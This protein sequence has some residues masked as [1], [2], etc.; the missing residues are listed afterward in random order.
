MLKDIK[1]LYAEDEEFIRENMVESLEFFSANVIAVSDGDTAYEVYHKEK[2]DI[3]IAD[4]EMP[5]MNGLVLA[6]NIRKKDKNVQIIITTA[7][8]NTQYL[9]K[10][11]ELNL[12]KYLTK[13]VRLIDL[14]KALNTCIE[15]LRA[16]DNPIKYF[17]DEDYY[18]VK[19]KKLIVDGK[20]V[21][22]DYQEQKFFTLLIKNPGRA[23]GYEEMENAIWRNGMSESAVRSLVFNLRKKLPTGVIK[24]V[25][26]TGYKIVIKE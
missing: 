25:P 1:I 20:E 16:L 23:V 6:E 21:Y 4:I 22:L 24:N 14:E 13:P 11:V 18:E 26:K 15:N 8:T 10:A 2:P 5:G 9:L 19:S 3:V 7:Y 12:I 17:N